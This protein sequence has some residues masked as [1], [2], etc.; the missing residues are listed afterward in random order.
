MSHDYCHCA[1]EKCPKAKTCFRAYLRREDIRI[2]QKNPDAKMWCSYSGFSPNEN[3]ECDHYMD[4]EGWG[5]KEDA[6]AGDTEK[7]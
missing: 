4:I 5:I 6:E 2:H 7:D 3:G 1:N